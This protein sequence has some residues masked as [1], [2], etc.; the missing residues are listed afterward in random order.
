MHWLLI[1]VAIVVSFA[2]SVL[3]GLVTVSGQAAAGEAGADV[4]DVR[5]RMPVV[6]MVAYAL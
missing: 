4:W 5:V 1:A 2:L 3:L 6:L